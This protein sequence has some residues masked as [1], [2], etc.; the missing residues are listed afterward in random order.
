LYVSKINLFHFLTAPQIGSIL[1]REG[2]A[3]YS[4][5]SAR[6]GSNALAKL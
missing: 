6:Q 1:S 3:S 5:Y 2:N 4:F